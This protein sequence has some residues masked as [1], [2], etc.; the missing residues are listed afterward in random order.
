MR[1]E[2]QPKEE[3]LS[4]MML[5]CALILVKDS[6]ATM[7]QAVM[8]LPLAGGANYLV[9][10]LLDPASFLRKVPSPISE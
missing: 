6:R 9:G 8:I 2:G 7:E 10:G 3:V 5:F 1:G 4:Y